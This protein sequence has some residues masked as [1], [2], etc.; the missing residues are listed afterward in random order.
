[1]PDTDLDPIVEVEESSTDVAPLLLEAGGQTPDSDAGESP[2]EPG[3]PIPFWKKATAGASWVV[4]AFFL[5]VVLVNSGED[6]PS[7]VV[8]GASLIT[9]DGPVE[10]PE[11]TLG[12]RFDQVQQS[13]NAAEHPPLITSPLRRTPES[14]E[15]DSFFYRFDPEAEVI[16]AYR[17]SDD[18]LVALLVRAYIG[19]EAIST[20]YLH[21][22]HLINPFSPECLDNYFTIGL[23]GKDMAELS[24]VGSE[25]VW[26]Y[27]GNE[28]RV[29]V[30][31]DQLTIRVLAPNAPVS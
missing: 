24:E 2:S 17:D 18:Y 12:I 3:T 28:W 8:A 7:N 4:A 30:G 5:F 21:L 23:Q 27:E 31:D 16:G 22:C 11:N 10:L 20:M 25:V 26:D 15:L 9:Q 13:W 19:H 29:T 1:M 14:G 6:A